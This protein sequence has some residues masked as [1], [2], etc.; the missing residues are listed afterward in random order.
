MFDSSITLMYDSMPLFVPESVL[1]RSRD[2]LLIE[3]TRMQKRDASEES[4]R[5]Y[6]REKK[7]YIYMSIYKVGSILQVLFHFGAA[8]PGGFDIVNASVHSVSPD[9]FVRVSMSAEHRFYWT[10]PMSVSVGCIKFATTVRPINEAVHLTL[11]IN[12][13]ERPRRNFFLQLER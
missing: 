7:P 12:S 8:L 2:E 1:S 4:S 11:D 6:A 13:N 5:L 9:S 10:T 3:V